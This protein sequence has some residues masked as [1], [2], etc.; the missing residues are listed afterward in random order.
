MQPGNLQHR[1]HGCCNKQF[2]D[3]FCICVYDINCL[4]MFF[5]ENLRVS[6]KFGGFDQLGIVERA[7]SIPKKRPAA[8]VTLD[9]IAAGAGV[10][11]R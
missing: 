11:R 5:Y 1:R 4:H 6:V 10:M 7:T 9:S 2:F 3:V 8:H